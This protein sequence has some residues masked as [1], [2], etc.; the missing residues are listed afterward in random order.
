MQNVWISG[1]AIVASRYVLYVFNKPN[2]QSKPR[3][4]SLISRDTIHS[5]VIYSISI[6]VLILSHLQLDLLSSRFW[7]QIPYKFPISSACTI[8]HNRRDILDLTINIVTLSTN[9]LKFHESNMLH[10]SWADVL[11]L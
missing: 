10:L 2:Y 4:Q 8:Y 6:S 11:L 1:S 3:L 7:N 5:T 9:K